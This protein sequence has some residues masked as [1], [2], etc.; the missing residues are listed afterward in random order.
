MVLRK[1]VVKVVSGMRMLLVVDQLL[2]EGKWF[3]WEGEEL[4]CGKVDELID[5]VT[6]DVK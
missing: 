1:Q 3:T 5:W 2:T 4:R 6:K